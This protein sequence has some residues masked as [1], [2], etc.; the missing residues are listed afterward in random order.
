MRKIVTV[1]IDRPLGTRHPDYPATVYPVNYGYIKD[2]LAPDG[3]AQDAY[4]LG[5]D[6]P[7]CSFTG[8]LAAVIHRKD[9]MEDKWI[10]VQPGMKLTTADIR[11]ATAFVEKYFTID[12]EIFH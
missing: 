11:E 4:V 12:I 8:E 6:K 7:L 3:E 1:Q 10:V 9:D 2:V 5:V